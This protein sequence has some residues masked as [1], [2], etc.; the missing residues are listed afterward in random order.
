MGYTASE[1]WD[2]IGKGGGR[3]AALKSL[4]AKQIICFGRDEKGN[5]LNGQ[6]GRFTQYRIPKQPTDFE[7]LAVDDDLGD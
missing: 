2:L 3:Y 7:M 1:L 5:L 4:A 6:D